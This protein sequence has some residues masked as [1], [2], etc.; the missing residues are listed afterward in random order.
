MMNSDIY[1]AW[2]GSGSSWVVSHRSCTEYMIF[3]RSQSL[4]AWLTEPFP[5]AT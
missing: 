3:L 1:V 5:T 4:R 2:P